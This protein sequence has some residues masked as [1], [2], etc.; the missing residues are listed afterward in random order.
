[1]QGMNRVSHDGKKESSAD[2]EL[3]EAAVKAV[4]GCQLEDLDKCDGHVV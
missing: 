2:S 4:F 3:D 1:M